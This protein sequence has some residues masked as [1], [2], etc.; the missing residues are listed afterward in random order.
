MPDKK[1]SKNELTDEDLAKVTGGVKVETVGNP[2]TSHLRPPISRA[3]EKYDFRN[4]P[5]DAPNNG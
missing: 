1:L 2:D 3:G 4:D 5:L